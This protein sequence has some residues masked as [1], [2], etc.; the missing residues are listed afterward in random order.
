[1][2]ENFEIVSRPHGDCWKHKTQD[3]WIVFYERLQKEGKACF[4]AYR[5][6]E[7]SFGCDPW[8]VNNRCVGRFF[9]LED[10]MAKSEDQ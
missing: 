2:N 7:G 4:S 8:T 1:M 9:T 10:A 6:I 5:A 3:F